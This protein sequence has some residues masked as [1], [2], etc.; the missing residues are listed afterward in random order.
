MKTTATKKAVSKAPPTTTKRTV[1][2]REGLE[3]IFEDL[4]KDIYWAEKHL[5]K[6]LPKMAKASHNDALKD[7]FETHLQQTQV[8]IARLEKCFTLIDK[9]AVAK[10]CEA[11]EGLL[12]EGTDVIDGHVK[13]HARDAA[14]IAAAQKVEH[15]E[16]SSYGTLRTMANVLGKVQCAALLEE[17]K[18]EEASTD[19]SLTT[20]SEKINQ[21]AVVPAAVYYSS[22]SNTFKTA[23][24][25]WQDF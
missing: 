20:L 17:T 9:K 8:Q 18:D 11:M 10:K 21:L 1:P 24:I 25:S 7:A 23:C 5:T 22:Q 14:L 13:G 15:Y 19:E 2:S 3:A 6:A 16:I 12:K 4:L